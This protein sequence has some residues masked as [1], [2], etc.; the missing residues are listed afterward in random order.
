MTMYC[1]LKHHPQA[2]SAYPR[3]HHH[4]ND[5]P[6]TGNMQGLKMATEYG[7]IDYRF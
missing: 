3:H 6:T 1:R 7:T 4:A 2:S 5:T